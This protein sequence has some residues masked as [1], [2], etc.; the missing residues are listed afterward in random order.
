MARR[1][2]FFKKDNLQLPQAKEYVNLR[3][4]ELMPHWHHH[5]VLAS[6]KKIKD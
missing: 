1:A 6:P 5:H 4:G 3:I 2:T